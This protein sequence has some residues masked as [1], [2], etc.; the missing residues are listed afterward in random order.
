M[1]SIVPSR[2]FAALLAVLGVLVAVQAGAGAP[3]AQAE[4]ASVQLSE[5]QQLEAVYTTVAVTNL[6]SLE[7]TEAHE[8]G[9]LRLLETELINEVSRGQA[10][11]P[12]AGELQALFQHANE[13]LIGH[14]GEG[15]KLGEAIADLN[16]LI[17]QLGLEAPAQTL[18]PLQAALRNAAQRVGRDLLLEADGSGS[19]AYDPYAPED[20]WWGQNASL[21]P[22]SAVQ[23]AFAKA[24]GD[25]PVED[26]YQAVLGPQVPEIHLDFKS[27]LAKAGNVQLGALGEK[28]SEK[29]SVKLLGEDS[30][31]LGNLALGEWKTA[32]GQ[33]LAG[34]RTAALK[35]IKA[36]QAYFA[37]VQ[38][39][40]VAEAD[41]AAFKKSVAELN[42]AV[43]ALTS[44]AG[45]EIGGA[46]KL[47]GGL[48]SSLAG[49]LITNAPAIIATIV[50][51]ALG[52][53]NFEEAVLTQLK[54][55]ETMI[56]EVSKQIHAGFAQVDAGIQEIN[57][58]LERDTGLL[59]NVQANIGAL[60]ND[61]ANIEEHISGLQADLYEIAKVQREEALETDLNID[62]GY[63][64]RAPGHV[65][66]PLTQFEQADGQFFTW[67]TFDAD[68]A[69]SE[70][71]QGDWPENA[72]EVAAK[73]GGAASTDAL[74]YN[75]DFLAAYADALGWTDGSSLP[76]RLPNPAVWAA[77]ANAFAQLLV[78]NP[79]Y[80]TPAVLD[81]VGRLEEV[82]E[83]ITPLLDGIL[84]RGEKYTTTTDDGVEID[85]GS[86]VL[87]HALEN[88]ISDGAALFNRID[89][90]ENI[91]LSGQNPGAEQEPNCEKCELGKAPQHLDTGETGAANINVFG[92]PEQEP[93]S[94]EHL[95]LFATQSAGTAKQE[96][97]HEP[98]AINSCSGEE[99]ELEL[100][101]PAQGQSAGQL[102]PVVDPLP[103]VFAN[104][105]HLGLG[106]LTACYSASETT[107]GIITS[108]SE[109]MRW[110][111]YD[112]RTGKNT[113]VYGIERNES[114]SPLGC[115]TGHP[116]R[117][118]VTL[119]REEPGNS[120]YENCVHAEEKTASEY[121]AHD[122]VV[123]SFES[124]F[125]GEHESFATLEGSCFV[126]FFCG[127]EGEGVQLVGILSPIIY[128]YNP[129]LRREAAEEVSAKLKELRVE[130]F[131]AFAPRNEPTLTSDNEEVRKGAEILNGATALF[132]DYVQLGVDAALPTDEVLGHA[133]YGPHPLLNNAAGSGQSSYQVFQYFTSEPGTGATSD[134]GNYF[135]EEAEAEKDDEPIPGNPV[136]SNGP[137]QERFRSQAK[138]VAQ[139]LGA[140]VAA[141]TVAPRP[142]ASGMGARRAAADAASSEASAG[143]LSSAD[144]L[145][146][147]TSQ[148]LRLSEYILQASEPPVITS[149]PASTTVV[150]PA[151]AS[152]QAT[153]SGEGVVQWEVSTDGGAQ[154]SADTNDQG[155]TTNTLTLASTSL[156]ENGY[157]YRARF[158]NALGSIVSNAATLTVL[159]QSSPPPP[160]QTGG[161]GQGKAQVAGLQ[162]EERLAA[163]RIVKAKLAK[164]A[165]YVTVNTTT[166]GRLTLKG[167]GLR[168]LTVTVGAG[169]RRL[170]VKLTKSGAKEA[171]ARKT[172]KLSSVLVVGH[173]TV[174]ATRKV[175]LR[176]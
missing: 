72:S 60:S 23:E 25:A 153:A 103:N 7:A 165:L 57:N 55:I 102:S 175:R 105:W 19:K 66:M 156:G 42:Q 48:A 115:D 86:S 94:S 168:T 101:N 142:G 65:A 58:T 129:A 14:T 136:A 45:S 133:L 70:L 123:K 6:S 2:R 135:L 176:P 104:A 53:E 112:K 167:P 90:E 67:G 125:A 35:S 116:L 36:F 3:A 39:G 164:G 149:Q 163:V 91:F 141:A 31:N 44:N 75:L 37:T 160:P 64:E 131:A 107:S 18:S 50:K 10:L 59:E 92:G 97:A 126:A 128:R 87:N 68:D 88:Y 93:V 173:R 63:S 4:E 83:S 76:V 47:L 54:N 151:P 95:P 41:S 1:R 171:A 84:T 111:W 17:S 109:A 117:N 71:P 8:D 110:Y 114:L 144:P 46:S 154:F 30:R 172:I 9:T 78:E 43:T 12:A 108:H 32:L 148:R 166:A 15:E 89:A 157:E 106:R 21:D 69:F 79:Q 99:A 139:A 124:F 134:A 122:G 29:I 49:S 85:T 56:E 146:S 51:F 16:A 5:Q 158:S 162:E 33:A 98:M 81:Q 161:G 155:A 170:K 145:I 100:Q 140:D 119:W 174:T 169:T 143:Q 152:F 20:L 77:G 132:D 137:L 34:E 11:A 13:R 159:G 80:V 120:G 27:L 40:N 62:L 127:T 22:Y 130:M 150:E 38:L 96:G 147:A 26:L 52:G 73:L 113:L 61:V 82:G 118:F 28:L 74:D 138:E 24:R 121:S